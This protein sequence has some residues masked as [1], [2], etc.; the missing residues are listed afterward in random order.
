M[1][2]KKQPA[3]PCSPPV[4]FHQERRLPGLYLYL[5]FREHLFH[6]DIGA[7]DSYGILAL[8]Q[9][10]T[11]W[12]RETYIPDVTPSRTFIRTLCRRYIKEQLAPCHLM[13]VLQDEL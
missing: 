6:P 7:Y 12:V 4:P 10:H 9:T 11:G 1:G 13:D 3:F 5:P 8:R 2:Y